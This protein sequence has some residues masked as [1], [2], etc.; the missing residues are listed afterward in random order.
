V[1]KTLNE[2]IR[3]QVLCEGPQIGDGFNRHEDVERSRE[4]YVD[5]T[6]NSMT[7]VELL[8]RISDQLNAAMADQHAGNWL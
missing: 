6:L 2:L 3:K 5:E 8:E 1:S 4:N 7:N